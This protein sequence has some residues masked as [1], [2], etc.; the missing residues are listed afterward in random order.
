M[1]RKTILISALALMAMA[2]GGCHL[3]FG[4]GESGGSRYC[5]DSGCYYCDDWGCYPDGNGDG[6]PGWTCTNNYD[7]ASGCYCNDQGLCEEGGF[8]SFDSDCADGFVCDDRSSCVPEGSEDG[9]TSDAECPSGAFCDEQ[10]GQCVGSWYCDSSD[11]N[12]DDS[13]GMG[14]E[15]DDRNTCVPE[16]CTDDSMC[17]EG[18]YCDEQAGEC[19]ETTTCDALGNCPGGLVCDESRNTCIPEDQGPT[20]Q[21]EVTCTDDAPICPAG[22][23]PEILDGCYTGNCMAKAD[24]PDGAPFECSDLNDDEDACIANPECGAVY[25]GINCTTPSG[26]ACTSGETNCSCESFAFDYCEAP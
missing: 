3:Y 15:C 4:D 24:C 21:G 14:F 6:E 25:K 11:P 5:D 20:C 17:Q 19:I 18:C 1:L 9:C 12:A 7:C 16:P 22:S 13:C 8:C 26:D 2:L 10:S 23:T